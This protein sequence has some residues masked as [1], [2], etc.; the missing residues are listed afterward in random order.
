M[1]HSPTTRVVVLDV[2]PA[3]EPCTMR[4]PQSVLQGRQVSTTLSSSDLPQSYTCSTS[5]RAGINSVAVSVRSLLSSQC[6]RDRWDVCWREEAAFEARKATFPDPSSRQVEDGAWRSLYEGVCLM[7][8]SDDLHKRLGDASIRWRGWID[9]KKKSL[10]G[11]QSEK[12]SFDFFFLHRL[13]RVSHFSRP[14]VNLSE[15]HLA[16]SLLIIPTFPHR[17]SENSPL[18]PTLSLQNPQHSHYHV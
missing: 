17:L 5:Q 13:W 18:F 8:D 1:L 4:Y 10:A 2:H 14:L 11:E 16:F 3:D 9:A 15:A 6:G 7:G 12:I